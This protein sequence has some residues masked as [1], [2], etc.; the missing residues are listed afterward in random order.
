MT[1][2]R[3]RVGAGCLG[4]AE[5]RL[6][7]GACEPRRPHPG[8]PD[9]AGDQTSVARAEAAPPV[10][11][12]QERGML[13]VLV[14]PLLRRRLKL[15]SASSGRPVQSLAADAWDALCRQHDM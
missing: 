15:V 3:W 2:P 10:P 8:S 9:V 1:S 5:S 7:R 13:C 14:T 11:G 4:A 6:G 12:D